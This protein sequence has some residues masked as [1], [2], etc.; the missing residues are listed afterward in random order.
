MRKQSRLFRGLV[1]LPNAVPGA[2]SV[3]DAPGLPHPAKS[4]SVYRPGARVAPQR[5]PILLDG[6]A[7]YHN[8]EPK[9][10]QR[11]NLC[12]PRVL[13]V[14]NRCPGDLAELH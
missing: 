7:G 1:R 12:V 4:G 10:R 14:S 11:K 6:L 13:V 9:T 8:D 2:S 5:C 3:H